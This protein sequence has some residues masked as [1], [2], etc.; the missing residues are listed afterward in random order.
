M[1]GADKVSMSDAGGEHSIRAELGAK[2]DLPFTGA[3]STSTKA[4][5]ELC[6]IL[7]PALADTEVSERL[8]ILFTLA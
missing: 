8:E 1:G 3:L 7:P 4:R 2:L 6:S 5:Q